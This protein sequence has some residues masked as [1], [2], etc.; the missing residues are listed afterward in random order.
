MKKTIQ[1]NIGGSV[2]FI[3]EDAY[4]S[5][6]NY[7]DAIKQHLANNEDRDEIIKDIELRIAELLIEKRASETHAISLNHIEEIIETMGQPEAYRMDDEDTEQVFTKGVNKKLFRDINDRFIAGVASGLAHYVGMD[8]VWMRLLWVLI[9]F[10]GVGS[11]ILIYI[12]LWILVPEARTTTEKLQMKGEPVNLSNIERSLKKEYENVARKVKDADIKGKTQSL[13][14]K[15]AGFFDWLLEAVKT[16]GRVFLFFIGIV[17]LLVS[18]IV[19]TT[20]I[21]LLFIPGYGLI[22]SD[23]NFYST[24]YDG[25]D[26]GTSQYCIWK[27]ASHLSLIIPFVFLFILSLFAINPKMKPV[28]KPTKTGL[29]LLWVIAISVTGYF[30]YNAKMANKYTGRSLQHIELP[31][32]TKDTLN[33]RSKQHPTLS[34]VQGRENYVL[35][36]DSLGK[37]YVYGS[38]FSLTIKPT[39]EETPSMVVEK[40]SKANSEDKAS[41]QAEKIEYKYNLDDNLLLLDDYFFLHNSKQNNT[42]KIRIYL[43]LPREMIFTIDQKLARK[44][45]KNHRNDQLISEEYLQVINESIVCLTCPEKEEQESKLENK[46]NSESD[47]EQRVEKAFKNKN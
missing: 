30:Y 4:Q 29:L 46:S 32:S 38:D 23:L 5:L 11:P 28:G 26:L 17:L 35:Q 42:S 43:N 7:L 47:W 40:S 18:F 3:D 44:N 24:L 22:N 1:I 31:M 45:I 15:S 8:P 14:K 10:A 36:K 19:I 12:I 33:I 6:A 25:V 39:N 13:K 34:H 27:T 9:V 20:F 41:I 16:I 2:F 37:H 21:V